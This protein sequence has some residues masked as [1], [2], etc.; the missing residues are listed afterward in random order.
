[1]Q[2]TL[3]TVSRACDGAFHGVFQMNLPAARRTPVFFDSTLNASDGA[4]KHGCG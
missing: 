2:R 3:K 1:M 4:E